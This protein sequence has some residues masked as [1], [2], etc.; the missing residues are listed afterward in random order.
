MGARHIDV[1]GKRINIGKSSTLVASSDANIHLTTWNLG[2]FDGEILIGDFCLLTP[3]VRIAAASKITIGDGC[4]F[5]NSCYISDADWHGLYNRAEPV[6]NTKPIVLEDNVWVGDRAIVGKG[7][8]IGKN[9]IVAAGAVVVKDVPPNV[10][11]GGN[12]AKIIKEL[13]PE[14]EAFTRIELFKDPQALEDLYDHLDKYDLKKN[15]LFGWLKSKIYPS[16]TD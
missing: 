14:K 9:S 1:F 3:G 8:T 6:G 7:V 15:S 10:I 11:V 4:M 16:R 13:D 5:A 2:D 12:P